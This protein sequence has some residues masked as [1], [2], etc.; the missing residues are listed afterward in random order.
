MAILELSTMM[1]RR[2]TICYT[3]FGYARLKRWVAGNSPHS[4]MNGSGC[5][6]Y[7]TIFPFF[8]FLMMTMYGKRRTHW[9]KEV[10]VFFSLGGWGDGARYWKISE[11]RCLES[12]FFPH[13]SAFWG[14]VF[15]RYGTHCVVVWCLVYLLFWRWV[16]KGKKKGVRVRV[17]RGTLNSQKAS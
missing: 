8:I 11:N 15:V 7:N 3:F 6:Q 13:W 12:N 4:T 10:V 2:G 14:V 5:L 16:G 1:T 9:A 17:R